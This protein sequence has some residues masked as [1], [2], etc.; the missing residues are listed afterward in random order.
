M[1]TGGDEEELVPSG[2][3]GEE[4]VPHTLGTDSGGDHGVAAVQGSEARSAV[5]V[6]QVPVHLGVRIGERGAGL[7]VVFELFA[8]QHDGLGL[9]DE[10]ARRPSGGKMNGTTVFAH[11][12]VTFAIHR[13]LEELESL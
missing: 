12:R 13:L 2:I 1:L 3:G 4:D 9:G 8:R 7:P 5:P 6:G 10:R 11:Y